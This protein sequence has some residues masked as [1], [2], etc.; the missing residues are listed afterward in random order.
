MFLVKVCRIRVSRPQY[1]ETRAQERDY[2]QPS[3][4]ILIARSSQQ[5]PIF[6]I[7]TINKGNEM[8]LSAS[9]KQYRLYE[10]L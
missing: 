2:D 1:D 9:Q 6:L 10:G 3:T 7:V 8:F 4:T 5:I